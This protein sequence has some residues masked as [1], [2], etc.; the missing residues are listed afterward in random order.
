MVVPFTERQKTGGGENMKGVF[1]REC[2]QFALSSLWKGEKNLK[3]D[4]R[5][6][7]ELWKITPQSVKA[8]SG[9]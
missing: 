6:L 1:L 5:G 9:P 2:G 3:V 8:I 7:W 4:P